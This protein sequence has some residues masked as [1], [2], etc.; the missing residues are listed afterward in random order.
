M[1]ED[2]EV[3]AVAEAVGQGTVEVRAGLARGVVAL[4]VEREGEDV[5]AAGEDA[6]G[7]VAL[8]HVAVDDEDAGDD[9]LVEERL[10]GDGHVVED[11]VAGAALGAGVVRAAGHVAGDPVLEREAGGEERAGR[12]E[13]GAAGDGGGVGQ[14]DGARLGGGEGLVR[15]PL[16]VRE[17]VDGGDAGDAGGGGGEEAARGRQQPARDER[18]AQVAVL[19]HREGVAGAE[20]RH[21]VGVED[22]GQRHAS[23]G[24]GSTVSS[25]TSTVGGC[26]R[27]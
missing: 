10:G 23:G 5:G 14:A 17:R 2:L 9:A 24:V 11:A 8:V 18:L 16:D 1:G 20:R 21:V 3:G 22:D 25:C 6:R 15:H 26:S 12:R 13:E 4:G 27:A 7:A 19:R